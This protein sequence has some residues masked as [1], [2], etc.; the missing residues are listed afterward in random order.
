MIIEFNLWEVKQ[1][2]TSR[3]HSNVKIIKSFELKP[4]DRLSNFKVERYYTNVL[5]QPSRHIHGPTKITI[6]R[7]ALFIHIGKSISFTY[8]R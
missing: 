4:Y 6:S 8:S 3:I 5:E 1:L 7:I 2:P